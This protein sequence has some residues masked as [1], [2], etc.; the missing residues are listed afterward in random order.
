MIIVD[1]TQNIAPNALQ[2]GRDYASWAWLQRRAQTHPNA[3]PA[4]ASLRDNLL[5]RV[6]LVFGGI[7]VWDESAQHRPAWAR[8]ISRGVADAQRIARWQLDHYQRLADD[9][10]QIRL[11]LGLQDLD[12]VLA[13]WCPKD[14]IGGRLHGIVPMLQGAAPVSEPKQI[15]EWLEHGLRIVAPAW[16]SN[17]YVTSAGESGDFTLLG[18]ELLEALAAYPV[19][20]DIARLPERAAAA[21]IERYEGAII[22][23]H[24]SPRRIVDH[25]HCLSD[26]L[27]QQLCE[28]D[29]VMGIMLYNRVLRRDWHPGDPKRRVTVSHWVEAVDHVC[30]LVGSAAHVGLGSDIDGGYAYSSL[31]AEIDTSCDLWLLRDALGQRGFS[32][33]E[34][35]AILSGNM[36][37]KLRE[38]WADG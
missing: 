10:P 27:I 19:L 28:R 9:N 2:L 32:D 30:Q 8:H 21:A 3:P 37:R 29:G 36:L 20:L 33:D 11:V 4:T 22:S 5:G 24:S 35:R 25:P 34:A 6:A 26:E 7:Q 15:E 23:S 17:R 18:Y 12:E 31:P 13:S 1:A 16:G 14:D 38:S